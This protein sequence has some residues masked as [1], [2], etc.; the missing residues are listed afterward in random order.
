MLEKLTKGANISN[1]LLQY[2]CEGSVGNEF[3]KLSLH[4]SLGKGVVLHLSSLVELSQE[5][6]AGEF[7]LHSEQENQPSHEQCLYFRKGG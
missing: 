2:F 7:L 1:K 3:F 5:I 6:I 4:V